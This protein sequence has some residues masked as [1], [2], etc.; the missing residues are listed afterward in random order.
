MSD[1]VGFLIYY[2]SNVHFN[3]SFC[4]NWYLKVLKSLLWSQIFFKNCNQWGLSGTPNID[5]VIL[6]NMPPPPM[7]F[8]KNIHSFKSL[9]LSCRSKYLRDLIFQTKSFQQVSLS[10]KPQKLKKLIEKSHFKSRNCY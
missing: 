9:A 2:F 5:F 3:V 4:I 8:P 10:K 1:H 6:T 7:K